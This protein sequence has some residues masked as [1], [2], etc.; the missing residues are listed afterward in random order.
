V[1][2][3]AGKSIIFLIKLTGGDRGKTFPPARYWLS[4]D[5]AKPAD[6]PGSN[7]E[8]HN[9]TNHESQRKQKIREQ[10]SGIRE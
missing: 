7:L 6:N 5:F 4:A 2:K 8:Q 1:I 10:L 9:R 3:F